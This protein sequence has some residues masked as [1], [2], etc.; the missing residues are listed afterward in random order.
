[1]KQKLVLGLFLII[2]LAACKKDKD[3]NEVSLNGKWT[4]ENFI[5]KVYENGVLI[6][7]ETEPGDG[8]TLDFQNN[9]NLVISS[10]GTG[11]ESLPYA[12]K[13]DSKVEIDGDIYEIR[14]LTGSKV[15]LYLREDYAPGE[16]DETL[17][18]LKR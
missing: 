15:T 13:P 8:T 16:Y 14:N 1:M 2:L 3:E 10:P 18:N 9:G 4:A 12:I 5:L 7:T 17:I 11:V 6:D